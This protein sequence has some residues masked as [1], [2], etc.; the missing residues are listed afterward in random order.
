VIGC[1]AWTLGDWSGSSFAAALPA[2]ADYI[3]GQPGTWTK[4]YLPLIEKEQVK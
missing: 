2:L 3:T 1:A 4:T